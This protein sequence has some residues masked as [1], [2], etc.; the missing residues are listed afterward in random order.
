MTDPPG[1]DPSDPDPSDPNPSDPNPSDIV[2]EARRLTAE[3]ARLLHAL[4]SAETAAQDTHAHIVEPQVQARLAAMPIDALQQ[5]TERALRVGA[6]E[7]AGLRTVLSVR[8]ASRHQLEAIKGVGPKTSGQLIAAAHQLEDAVR[9]S[10]KVRFDVETQ[11]PQHADL[12]QALGSLA[13]IQEA[14][15]PI[16]PQLVALASSISADLETARLQTRPVRR[17]FAGRRRK[18]A[19]QAALHRL[20]QVVDATTTTGLAAQIQVAIEVIDQK[21]NASLDLWADYLSRPIFYNGVLAELTGAADTDAARGFLPTELVQRI[22]AVEL[23]QSLLDVSLRGYQAFGAKFA[24][25]QVRTILG[26]EMGLGKTI[27]ALAVLCHL[28]AK[29]YKHFLVVCPASVLANWEHETARHTHL[30]RVVRLHGPDRAASIKDWEQHGGVAITTFGTLSRIDVPAI[31]VAAIV[32][33]EAHYVKNPDAKRTQA[34]E[35]WLVT[36]SYTMLMS[37]TPMENRVDEFKALVTMVR[38]DVARSIDPN[39]GLAGA[40]AFRKAVAPVYLRRN[41]EDVLDELPDKIETDEWI[42]LDGISFDTYR[43]AVAGGNFMAMRRAAFMT[44]NPEDS[45]KLF[46]LREIVAEAVANGRKVI[47]FS[48]FRDVLDRTADALGGQVIGQINGTVPASERQALI[49]RFTEHL[50]PC[51]L[52]SQIEAGGVGLNIQAASVVIITEPQWKP[53]TEEQAIARSHRMGQTRTVD[54]HRLLTEDSVD[55]HMVQVLAR[56]S[57]L[58]ADYARESHL[59]DA[60]PGAIDIT[61]PDAIDAAISDTQNEAEIIATEQRRLGI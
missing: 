21:A 59:R 14:V 12:L 40:D 18:E 9:R 30:D 37:G 26:D 19:S 56:K 27:Q 4:A 44:P 54:V 3:A 61:N 46:R 2:R 8:Q 38:P 11:P 7:D 10:T 15:D 29:G 45:P 6:V 34:L 55:E 36:P 35:R 28:Q 47:V 23:D 43:E 33:D 49:D 60:A 58:F 41:Q 13:T 24:L 25:A 22:N 50:E 42:T 17:F 5:A 31:D 51:V 48:Y 53:S 52:I 32:V 39:A 1:T 57:A 20:A 16:R